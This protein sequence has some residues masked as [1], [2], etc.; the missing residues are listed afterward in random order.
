MARELERFQRFRAV[1]LTAADPP[2]L[3]R[4]DLIDDLP[5]LLDGLP[6]CPRVRVPQLGADLRGQGP[7]AGTGRRP[8]TAAR[9]RPVSWFSAEAATVVPEVPAT[10]TEDPGLTM[11][12]LTTFRSGDEQTPCLGTSHPHLA[13][14]G[15]QSSGPASSPAGGN[16]PKIEHSFVSGG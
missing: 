1:D 3:V 12:G 15:W 9:Q 10:P 14:I 6:R 2:T 11:L 5:A 8:P 16:L 4:G 13:W 7:A